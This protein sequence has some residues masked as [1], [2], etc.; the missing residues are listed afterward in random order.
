M[1]WLRLHQ[2][3]A[4]IIGLTLL[5]PTILYINTLLS[6]L[7]QRQDYQAEID[8]LEPRVARL[9][10]LIE[11]EDQLR[12]SAG[13]VDSRVLNLVYPAED[14]RA[15]V[16]AGLQKEMRQILVEAGLSVSNSQVLPVREEEMFDYIGVKLTVTGSLVGLDAA[17]ARIAAYMPLVIVESLDAWP[18]RITRRSE[19]S[20]KQ[21]VNVTLQLLSL[22]ALQ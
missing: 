7:G 16:A 13:E 15:T 9:Q 19:Q 4:W 12:S 3:S 11:F 10:G 2:R 6:L 18:Q 22:R 21:V 1:S 20:D 5:L 17:L 14:D 8:R